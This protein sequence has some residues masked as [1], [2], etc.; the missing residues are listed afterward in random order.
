M[1][2]TYY[3]EHSIL[4]KDEEHLQDIVRRSVVQIIQKM[5]SE[6]IDKMFNIKIYDPIHDENNVRGLAMDGDYDAQT[7]CER[8]EIILTG[9]ILIED[10][11]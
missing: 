9:G 4:K 8:G 11:E 10:D 1:S 2:R 3:F 7:A 6:E 5:T